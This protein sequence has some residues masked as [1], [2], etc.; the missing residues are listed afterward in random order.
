MFARVIR[1]QATPEQ[2]ESLNRVF[3]EQ[4]IPI[5]RQAKGFKG[6]SLLADR[7]AGKGM[8]ISLWETEADAEAFGAA[9]EPAPLRTQGQTLG[10]SA[11]VD[12]YEV[13]FQSPEGTASAEAE[14]K[15]A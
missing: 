4:G 15:Y 1:V 11:H 10:L 13:A 12:T 14:G 9:T 3:R 8:S 6:Q 2:G 7:K 5:V